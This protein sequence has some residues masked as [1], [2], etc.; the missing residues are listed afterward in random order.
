MP[1][2]RLNIK[3]ISAGAGS[4]KTY[5]LTE[6]MVA[7][8][9]SGEVRPEGIV[10]T[11]FTSL[12]AAELRERVAE[13]LLEKGLRKAAHRLPNALI[14]T[15]HGLGVKLLNR[16]AY[17]AGIPPRVNI[18]AEEDKQH[19]FNQA[20]SNILDPDRADAMDA[21]AE[22]LAQLHF[23]SGKTFWRAQVKN[24]C[25]L[26]RVNKLDR[27]ALE[28]SKQQSVE[29]LLHLLGPSSGET[30]QSWKEK[31]RKLLVSTIEI[32]EGNEDETKTTSNAVQ[33]LSFLLRELDFREQFPWS[34]WA[35]ASKIK[36]GKKSE[37][38]VQAL[39]AF[40]ESHHQHRQLHE[41]IRLFISMM[42]D[43]AMEALEEYERF[44]KQRGLIDYNDME[45]LVYELLDDSSVQHTLREEMD[46]LMVDEF[47][48][49]SPIQLAIF[50]KLSKLARKVIWVG[51]PKQSI[52]GFRGAEPELMQALLEANGG[53]NPE[54]IL[55]HSWRSRE[56]IVRAV[57]A[58]FKKAFPLL[59]EEQICLKPKRKTKADEESLNLLDEP[60]GM[61]AAL[62][63][64]HFTLE[65]KKP[66]SGNADWFDLA[67]AHQIR[68]WLES[69]PLILPK[70]ER[71]QYRPLQAAE[72]AV[73]CR[74]NER[75][76]KVAKALNQM[77]LRAA[78][79]REGL[80][81]T[82]EVRLMLAC[83]KYVLNKKDALSSAEI[84]LL[85]SGR[86][87]EEIADSRLR[88]LYEDGGKEKKAW[89][90]DD[91]FLSELNR[92][93][94]ETLELSGSELLQ[95]LEDRLDL[96]RVVMR[97]GHSEQR[98]A[99]L[100]MLMKFAGE[101]EAHCDRLH[102]AASV[103]GLLIWL[104]SLA[105]DK[106]DWQGFSE[107]EGAVRVLTYH[108]SKG[109]EFPAV[110]CYELESGLRAD[111]IWQLQVV[112][113]KGDLQPESILEGRWLRFWV[114]PYGKQLGGTKLEE[115]LKESALWKEEQQ[116]SLGE[117]AR[118]L[119]VGMTRARDYLI[120]PSRFNRAM[121]WLDITFNLGKEG[122][123]VLDPDLSET[124]WLVDD[125]PLLKQNQHRFFPN[126]FEAFEQP[127]EPLFYLRASRASA[128]HFSPYA[129]DWKN[130]KGLNA[131][132]PFTAVCTYAPSLNLEQPEKL[133]A[134]LQALK[135]FA[136]SFC[137][138]NFGEKNF[139]QQAK[140]LLRKFSLPD[141]C[142]ESDLLRRTRSFCDQW[143]A[144]HR[145]SSLSLLHSHYPLRF[146][147]EGAYVSLSLDSLWTNR[148]GAL[149]VL[150]I[151]DSPNWS[152]G[153][154]ESWSRWLDLLERHMPKLL[155]GKVYAAAY[156]NVLVE[157]KIYT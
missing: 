9:E 60:P 26:A 135:I 97:W 1:E 53:L 129:L 43:L 146:F 154:K 24:L 3:I 112:P 55:S 91:A 103:G 81:E 76:K 35:K 74:R 31:L 62:Q 155:P 121:T 77:G 4:G 151:E 39:K 50:L 102:T 116:R 156:L 66:K 15:V 37:A 95:L 123:A 127:S 107:D 89:E 45:V 18:M 21:L 2:T 122:P 14:G 27:Q 86:K 131:S 128:E 29:S 75:C 152:A 84:L 125:E 105:A 6:E 64:W 130:D 67:L 68:S 143:Q 12:A 48:D 140:I 30:T 32:L 56:D 93:R 100:D 138:G 99:N 136:L 46:L 70:G 111:G 58:H 78:I 38:D 144:L 19:F 90:A 126:T 137:S 80:L 148:K 63:H 42:F 88:W 54:N 141:E 134:F 124:P 106:L 11:T 59:P 85:A 115:R 133:P 149:F 17:E 28:R 94:D 5:R 82:R 120:F 73:L 65:G 40:A 110:I 132:R 109:L 72:V 61:E 157:G 96:R 47:Q 119:Y 23:S 69:K 51:D 114:N 44:K 150:Q 41:D 92:L 36:V 33:E 147:H 153:K 8:L 52:Y 83:V 142:F 104:A 108:K 101:Y 34:L 113:A 57:N 22:S 25:D 145:E 49:T 71:K 7:L 139:E 10:A 87:L 98:L 16:F 117:M 13:R 118:L 20:L 79:Y